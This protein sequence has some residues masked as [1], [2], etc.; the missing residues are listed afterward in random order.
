M[1][2]EDHARPSNLNTTRHL[3]LALQGRSIVKRPTRLAVS[4]ALL[5]A[6]SSVSATAL[7]RSAADASC[8]AA[9]PALGA[10]TLVHEDATISKMTRVAGIPVAI[11]MD[12]RITPGFA[13][14]L[15]QVGGRWCAVDHFNAAAAQHLAGAD[16]A[17]IASAFAS[18]AGMQYLGDVSVSD[19]SVAGPVVTLRT[20]GGRHGAVSDWV[21]TVDR[22]GVR[23]ASF[24]TTGWGK[25]PRNRSIGGFEGVTSLPGHSRT[26]ARDAAGL[27]SIDATVDDL[28]ER[29]LREREAGLAK[30]AEIAGLA[31]GDDL[32]HTFSDGLTIKVSY[33]MSPFTP[34]AGM[35]TGVKQ[36]DRLRR[37]LSGA[38]VSYNDFISWGVRDP[39]GNTSRTFLGF[40]TG[41]P[42]KAGYINV[43]SPMA[44]VCLACAYL[45]DAMEI[46]VALLF[47]EI[48]PP[49]VGISYPDTEQFLNGVMG[50]EMVH[51]L[52]GG[53]S[54][55]EGG[56][57]SDAFTEGTARA[58]ESLHDDASHTYQTGSIAYSDSA[59]GCEG[60]ENGRSSWINAQANG[61]FVGHTY[62]A[63]YFWWTYYA[64]H[65]PQGLTALLEAM[66]QALSSSTGNN[67]AVRNVALLNAASGGNGALDLARW[68]AAVAAGNDADGFTIPA[69]VTG[70]ELNWFSLLKRATRAAALAPTQTVT[71]A[72]GGV[73]AYT[74]G[75]AGTLTAVPDGAAVYVF[76]NVD[77]QLVPTPA[78]VGT[79]VSEGQIVVVVAPAV[80]SFSG[81]LTIQ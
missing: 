9:T 13:S 40:E 1:R 17:T 71:V 77:R 61:P 49:L 51:S 10:R 54:D 81:P 23:S 24:T 32:K 56:V 67:A 30:A 8:G 52:Q 64:T 76:S 19:V 55:G 44:P 12:E 5:M 33:G 2:Q 20:A 66:P 78:G 39:F 38:I 34:D 70:T 74:A 43:D 18:V 35:D 21:V 46:H 50:H 27:V 3:R 11:A 57:F 59:N 48:A 68:G 80:G 65:G 36:A 16:A 28:L 25:S 7:P 75:I 4:V 79:P 45:V 53:Y 47:P 60:F 41:L 14:S 73:R 6:L 37:I 15:L 42:E 26:F 62:D 72:N 69:G 63:C 31:P 58:S 22:G 29:S